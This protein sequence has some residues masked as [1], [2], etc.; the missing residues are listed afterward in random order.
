M[1]TPVNRTDIFAQCTAEQVFL[2]GQ[3]TCAH[4]NRKF[5]R[6]KAKDAARE[7]KEAAAMQ[8]SFGMYSDCGSAYDE[9]KSCA[10]AV[11]H[12]RTSAKVSAEKHYKKLCHE[13]VE[14][15][16]APEVLMAL[17]KMLQRDENARKPRL[18]LDGA[19]WGW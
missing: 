11:M 12:A 18:Q 1:T 4:S 17:V 15:G 6:G 14:S 19:G 13:F 2:L 9:Q 3:V 16:G 8:R 7:Y 10:H 5:T